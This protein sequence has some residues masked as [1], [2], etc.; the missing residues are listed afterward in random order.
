MRIAHTAVALLALSVAACSGENSPTAAAPSESASTAAPSLSVAAAGQTVTINPGQN[1]QQ[2]VKQHPA[3]TTY[4]L[5]P[6]TYS[7][8]TV[9]PK[10]GDTF[11]GKPGAIMDG[12]KT[13]P[14]AFWIGRKPYPNNV[15]IDGIIIK[16]YNPPHQRGAITAGLGAGKQASGWVIKNCEVAYNLVNYGIRTGTKTQVL[17]NKI[18]HND[19]LGVSGGA[20]DSLLIEG[21]E[22]SYNNYK[23]IYTWG[24]ELGGAKFTNSRW[25]TVRNNFVHH[26][27]GP[28]LW[29]DLNNIHVIYEGNRVEDNSGQGIFHEISYDAII[30]NNTVLRN[31]WARAGWYYG[32]GILVGHS[33]NVEV[34][35]NIVKDNAHGIAGIQQDRSKW[36]AK[37]GA[38]VLKN[39]HVHDNTVTTTTGQAAAVADQTNNPAVF[40]SY[41]NRFRNN[42]Y[43][44]NGLKMPFAW[45]GKVNIAGW[46]G[47]GHDVSG[48]FQ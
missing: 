6:G 24:W 2:I 15:T 23:K 30:R 22:I 8:Q 25:L 3:G 16:N 26:N 39:F 12:G 7:K 35:G 43:Y 20:G 28:G 17:N 47:F 14:Y 48:T 37:Y 4:I 11:I 9:V 46:K 33:P 41:N 19:L 38:H 27:E 31:G 29:T 21:N 45:K 34:Y 32:S 18:H 44:L 40:G 42:T 36:V 13:A 10:S 5:N 1:I